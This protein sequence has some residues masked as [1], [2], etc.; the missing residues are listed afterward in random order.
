MEPVLKLPRPPQEHVFSSMAEVVHS[1]AAIAAEITDSAP[2]GCIL[3]PRINECLWDLTKL[4]IRC[5]SHN[6]SRPPRMFGDDAANSSFQSAPVA[7]HISDRDASH[8]DEALQLALG[9]TQ[10]LVERGRQVEGLTPIL[11]LAVGIL[12]TARRGEV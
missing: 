7:L 1:V 9:E 8:L 10:R 4:C 2:D 3:D 12:G 6:A 5:A 11:Q